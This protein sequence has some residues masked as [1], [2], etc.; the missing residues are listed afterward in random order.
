MTPERAAN[1]PEN[2]WRGKNPEFAEPKLTENLA[3]AGRLGEVGKRHG[4]SAGEA[5]IAWTLR[6]PAVTAAIVGARNARQ[7][8][9]IVGAADWTLDADEVARIEDRAESAR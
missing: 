9:G 5:A 6:H 7:V 8:E 3:L 2:D 1:F 4:R